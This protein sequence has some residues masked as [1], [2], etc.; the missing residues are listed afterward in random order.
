MK[1]ITCVLIIFLSII[2]ISTQAQEAKSTNSEF[3]QQA[4]I[5]R[6]SILAPYIG[7]ERKLSE[8]ISVF[9][10]I[11]SGVSYS[12]QVTNNV[13]SRELMF[14]PYV[15]IEPRFFLGMGKRAAKGKRIDYFSGYFIGTP[16]TV[17]LTNPEYSFG[18]ILGFQRAFKKKVFFHIGLGSVYNITESDG[19]FLPLVDYGLG[20]ILN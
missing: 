18:S 16:L 2:T 4:N 13:T 20:F 14:S 15:D 3:K 11:G 12:K 19:E 5:L 7:L 8:T 17:S 10:R 6:L 9:G 1:K